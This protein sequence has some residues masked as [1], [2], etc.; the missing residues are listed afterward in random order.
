MRHLYLEE[1]P[2]AHATFSWERNKKPRR[3]CSGEPRDRC[4][5]IAAGLD[6]HF[7]ARRAEL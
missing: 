6:S 5:K 1:G 7:G 3:S 2:T 4:S